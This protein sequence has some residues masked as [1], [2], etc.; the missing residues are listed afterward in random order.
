MK[1]IKALVV[2]AALFLSLPV[3]SQNNSYNRDQTQIH[4]TNPAWAPPYYEGARY[5]Y[6]PDIE[7]YY[8]L[9][10][11]EFIYLRNGLWVYSPDI[12]S[13]YADFDWADCFAIVLNVNVFRPW[14]HHQYYVSHYPRYYYR[15][16]YDH[17]NI[18]YVRG[19]NENLR[20]AI[21]WG[22]NE[23]NRA[24]SWDNQHQKNDRNFRY[25]KEDR[26]QQKSTRYEENQTPSD[27]NRNQQ[28]SGNNTVNSW[29]DNDNTN[30]ARTARP[31]NTNRQQS[32]GTSQTR[33]YSTNYYGK[34]IGNPVKVEKQ[35]QNR[36]FQKSSDKKSKSSS[37]DNR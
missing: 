35:M 15:D 30:S 27:N 22:E 36:T 4:Y 26:H 29:S 19:F 11:N 8:D 24:R 31:D 16:Y 12:P 6:L 28:N 14:M 21:Y 13:V 25:T 9:S 34:Q 3:F 33:S 5:Y 2:L 10:T 20:R 7:S 32:A 17:S 23:K 37:S 18:P 1:R